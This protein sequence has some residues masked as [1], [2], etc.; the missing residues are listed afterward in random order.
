VI[1]TLITI[2][3]GSTSVPVTVAVYDDPNFD[4]IGFKNF[5]LVL[6]TNEN[7][8]RITND[9]TVVVVFDNDCKLKH[10]SSA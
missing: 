8:A 9:T 10:D 6:S 4:A 2:T 5:S 1:S 7:A 3:P